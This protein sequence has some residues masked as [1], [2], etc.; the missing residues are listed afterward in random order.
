MRKV[1]ITGVGM[2]DFGKFE[3]RG[4]RDLGTAAISEAM[5]D[6]GVS[7]TDIDLVVHANA[8][9]GLLTGQE[10]IRGQVVTSGTD[11]AGL[12]LVNVENACASSSSG[13]H[14]AMLAIQS[15][16]YD[17]VVVAGVE[18]MSGRGTSTA[19]AAL[20][21]AADV[22]RLPEFNREMTG[23][24]DG[25]ESFFMEAY[26]RQTA[27]YMEASGATARDFAE[28]AAKNS[29][30][31]SLN[32][33]AQYRT[34]RSADEVLASRPV[35]GVLTMLMCS[36]I[37]DGAAAVVL[38]ATDRLRDDQR[39]GAVDLRASVVL[40]GT[41]GGSVPGLE[42]RAIDAAYERSGVGPADLDLAEVHDAASPNELI[43][44]EALGLC[45]PGDAPKLLANGATR[46][47]G[48]I[49][50]NT[51]GGLVSKGHPVGATGAAQVFELVTQLRGRAGDRQVDGA[52]VGIAESAGGYSHPEAAVCAVTIV[53][54]DS[55]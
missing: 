32:P 29:V 26:A 9:G 55:S 8:V 1:S 15:G 14:V 50:V 27:E 23:N 3:S 21:S 37:A 39:A 18:K 12:P 16:Q 22:D 35:A 53:S 42:H 13:I 44:I 11:L 38:Q 48:R 4:L 36:P 51:S 52:R 19:L 31:A 46:L 34:I 7:A 54:K 24:E 33:H 43:M 41:P 25:V 2:T 20:M 30:H 47:G 5:T 10:M 17:T 28:V 6:A 40:T 49:P 45:P